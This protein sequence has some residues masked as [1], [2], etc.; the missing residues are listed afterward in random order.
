MSRLVRV[1]SKAPPIQYKQT[2]LVDRVAQQMGLQPGR[3]QRELL[4]IFQNAQIENRHFFFD[5]LSQDNQS[6]DDSLSSQQQMVTA[7]VEALRSLS[8]DFDCLMSTTQMWSVPAFDA[9]LFRELSLRPTV[10]R[11]PMVGLASLGGAKLLS[12]SLHWAL[13]HPGERVAVCAAETTAS[14]G[15]QPAIKRARRSLAS[16]ERGPLLGEF[17]VTSLLAD[18]VA[19]ALVVGQQDSEKYDMDWRL[20]DTM[21]VTVP[22][23]QDG[24][25][26]FASIDGYRSQLHPKLAERTVP[27]LHQSLQQFLAKHNLTM[28]DPRLRICM[29]PGGPKILRTLEQLCNWT[30]GIDDESPLHNSWRALR[31]CGNCSSVSIFHVG[32]FFTL[33]GPLGQDLFLTST[34][35]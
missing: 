28:K 2:E 24:I 33:R 15:M 11:T 17:V 9:H 32:F 27:L 26:R 13:G 34:D 1:V 31:D 14:M 21:S 3:S 6:I 20:I 12:E 23:T 5:P 19:A 35:H 8:S 4:S 7:A 10:R 22:D 30:S 16:A 29:H 25:Q 18:G